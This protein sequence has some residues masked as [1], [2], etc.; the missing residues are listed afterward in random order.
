MARKNSR[1]EAGIGNDQMGRQRIQ[2]TLDT[3]D[4]CVEGLQIDRN[5]GSVLFHTA[6]RPLSMGIRTFVRLLL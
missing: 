6:A 5:I 2:S 3:F 4:R 1:R